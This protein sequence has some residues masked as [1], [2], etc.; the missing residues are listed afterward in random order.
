MEYVLHINKSGEI[1]NSDDMPAGPKT[2]KHLFITSN[3]ITSF[4]PLLN[5]EGSPGEEEVWRALSNF[6]QKTSGLSFVDQAIHYEEY[7]PSYIEPAYRP[8]DY[9]LIYDEVIDLHKVVNSWLI[10]ESQSALL[11]ETFMLVDPVWECFEFRSKQSTT[12]PKML[13]G[14]LVRAHITPG[15]LPA[16]WLE[17]WYCLEHEIPAR[18]CQECGKVFKLK[19]PK[20]NKK[21]C[22]NKCR[23]NKDK[24]LRDE[25][26]SEYYRDAQRRRR[27]RGKRAAANNN[28][29]ITP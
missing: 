16:C 22:S 24:R 17:V 9:L 21:T 3:L 6:A 2:G 13:D 1:L 27:G 18:I 26:G 15:L 14:K 23:K 11:I 28:N 25:R 7:Y 12:S 8:P 5:K 10:G 20:H 4:F 19:H 29:S